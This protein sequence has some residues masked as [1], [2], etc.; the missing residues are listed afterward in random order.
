MFIVF[1]AVVEMMPEPEEKIK[2]E[3]AVEYVKV[4]N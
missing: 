3:P 4:I 2:P 1:I